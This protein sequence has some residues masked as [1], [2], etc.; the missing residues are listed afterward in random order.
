MNEEELNEIVSD[1]EKN[2]HNNIHKDIYLNDKQLAL[3]NMYNINYKDFNSLSSLIF[4]LEN[5]FDD[6]DIDILID[7]LSEFNYYHNTNK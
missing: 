7:E 1:I 6:E 5:N 3:L 4:Y 2:M